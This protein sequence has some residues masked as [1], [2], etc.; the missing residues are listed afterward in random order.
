VSNV[1]EIAPMTAGEIAKTYGLRVYTIGVGTKGKALQPV[2]MYP[3]GQLEYDYVDVEIDE[4]VMTKIA[5]MTGGKYFRA[6]NKESLSSIYKEIDKLEKTI[7][8]EK[9]FSNKAEH[10][11][12]LG[13]GA[14]ISL[15]LEFIL[16]RIVF[17]SAP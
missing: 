4:D 8:S 7:I 16:K 10:F 14:L 1:G 9:S 15:L 17:K 5:N 12:P 13:I 2:A 3:N 11:L 6:T